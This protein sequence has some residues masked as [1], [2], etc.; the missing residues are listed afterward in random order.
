LKDVGRVE[1]V[2]LETPPEELLRRLRKDSRL[3][4]YGG[5]NFGMPLPLI[6]P[7]RD[8]IVPS[9]LFF[10]RSNGP[11][12]VL[13]ATTWRLE[14]TGHVERPLSLALDDLAAL[15]R[16]RL[17]A[18]LE[19]AGNGRTRF[20]PVPPGTPWVND[21]IGNAIWEG[22]ALAD[23]L[24]AACPLPGAVDVVTQGADFPEMRRGL[25]LAAARDPD[26]L[27]VWRMNGEPLP[28][29]HGG[30]VRL[31]VPGWAGIA[32]TKWIVGIDIIDRPFAGFWNSDNY[33]F[34]D[35]R[36]A[37][38]RPVAE[39]PPKSLIVA[40]ADGDIVTA[41]P[42]TVA[43]WA[44]SGFAPVA[45]VDVGTDDGISWQTATLHE[46]ERRGWR[47]WE[48]TW[49]A[50][51]GEHRLL[52]RATDERRLS[53]PATAPWNA[54]GYLMNAIHQIAVTVTP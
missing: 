9:D 14:V 37:P 51:P 25:P 29:A 8:R 18:F 38:L 40:P 13:D 17:E 33:V 11:V 50:P 22:V 4:P 42:V 32:S 36:G 24:A 35:E 26:I 52:A 41:G 43:G 54:R 53:Q 23:V 47:R 31:L 49:D 2:D 16:R 46:G 39:M 6:E 19:C 7:T 27:L 30:P 34:W 15:S 10:I 12:P 20:D 48:L 5:A 44:W 45:A 28:L 3:I 1:F 21:A